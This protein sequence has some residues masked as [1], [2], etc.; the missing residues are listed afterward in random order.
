M[1]DQKRNS[2]KKTPNKSRKKSTRKKSK[3]GYTFKNILFNKITGSLLLVSFLISSL[4]IVYLDIQITEK[5]SGKIWSFP[6]SVYAR[7]LE[8]FKNKRIAVT[9]I[10]NELNS[11]DYVKIETRPTKPGQYRIYN[12]SNI[13]FISRRFEFGE[14]EQLSKGVRLSIYNGVIEN[15]EELNSN[16]KIAVF[17]LEPIKIAGIYPKQKEERELIKLEDVPDDLILALLA[18]EDRRYYEHWGIDPV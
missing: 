15:I 12:H 7:P 14:A 2:P 17:R 3:S 16:K 9:D 5:M 1:P 18:V 8:L 6:S 13:E 4:Y 10:I 11:L